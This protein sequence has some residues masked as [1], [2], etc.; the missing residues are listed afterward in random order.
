MGIFYVW[1]KGIGVLL[2][3]EES[4]ILYRELSKDGRYFFLCWRDSHRDFICR[5]RQQG[6]FW[7]FVRFAGLYISAFRL[8]WAA[9]G[10]RWARAELIPHHSPRHPGG[11][12]EGR[13]RPQQPTKN[14]NRNLQHKPPSSTSTNPN[15]SLSTDSYAYMYCLKNVYG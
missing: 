6:C 7:G 4:L 15:S 10:L 14:T 13:R 3:E 2:V 9:P 8:L 12:R 5:W 11:G 1:I